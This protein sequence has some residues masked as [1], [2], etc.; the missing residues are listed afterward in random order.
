MAFVALSQDR[1][2]LLGVARLASGPDYA[3]A[4]YA[5]IVRSDLKGRGLGWVLMRH[6][7]H[8]AEKEG[9]RELTGDVLASNQRM[10]D[11]CRALGFEI[12]TDPEDVSIRKV[13]LKLP[14]S[15]QP[16]SLEKEP[17]Y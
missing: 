15:L 9:L 10:L 16:V 8:Y 7:I 14:T 3:S 2:E 17:A 6:L 12:S 5:I 11:M 1:Q 4:E 13:R